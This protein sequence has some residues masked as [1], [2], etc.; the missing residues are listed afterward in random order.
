MVPVAELLGAGRV[1]QGPDSRPRDGAG[2]ASPGRPPAVRAASP[3][4]TATSTQPELP[5]R[6]TSVPGGR[7]P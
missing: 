7:S 5:I 2:P 6:A 1:V 4:T 3:L